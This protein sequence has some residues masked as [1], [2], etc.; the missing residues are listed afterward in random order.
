MYVLCK[1]SAH[2]KK[3]LKSNIL[4]TVRSRILEIY[5][6][7]IRFSRDELALVTYEEKF[8]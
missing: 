5:W 7:V 1:W 8:K 4:Y 3:A 2:R 6:K